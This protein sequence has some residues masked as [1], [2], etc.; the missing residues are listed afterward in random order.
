MGLVAHVDPLGIV[1]FE[2]L[3]QVLVLKPF[4]CLMF[5]ATCLRMILLFYLHLCP[6]LVV[7][8]CLW[9]FAFLTCGITQHC[10]RMLFVRS[11]WCWTIPMVDDSTLTCFRFWALFGLLLTLP[12]NEI[13]IIYQDEPCRTPL[14]MMSIMTLV[15]LSP[16]RVS[17]LN[18]QTK[19]DGSARVPCP[20]T[21]VLDRWCSKGEC[22]LL[23]PL[24]VRPVSSRIR[25]ICCYLNRT[26]SKLDADDLYLYPKCDIIQQHVFPCNAIGAPLANIMHFGTPLAFRDRV[27]MATLSCIL[28][29]TVLAFIARLTSVSGMALLVLFSLIGICPVKCSDNLRLQWSKGNPSKSTGRSY[30]CWLPTD[31]SFCDGQICWLTK[32]VRFLCIITTLQVCRIGEA[33]NPGPDTLIL[34]SCNPT[35]VAFKEDIFTEMEF[36]VLGVSETA[37]TS[38]VQN[39]LQNQLAKKNIKSK[40]SAPVRPFAFS[41]SNMRGLAGGS[42]I[43]SPLRVRNTCEMHPDFAFNQILRDTCPVS[44]S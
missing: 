4:D 38:K 36:S 10:H 6:T 39:I 18:Q 30:G 8:G 37:A 12:L 27:V 1:D 42:A 44:A 21:H 34:R 17:P 5:F 2:W 24:N 22:S 31:T 16:W 13:T 23:E 29:L 19:I 14:T 28:I 41:A 20:E 43:F 40:L 32:F 15:L 35:T 26:P 9:I 25:E 11:S 33:S 7:H 3:W